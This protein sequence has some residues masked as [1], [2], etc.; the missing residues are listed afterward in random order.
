MRTFAQKPK[1]TPQSTPTR[2]TKPVPAH[3]G[4][5]RAVKSILQLQRTIGNQAVQRLLQPTEEIKDVSLT[6]ASYR[7]THDFSRMPA[8]ASVPSSIQPK[9]KVNAPGDIYEQEADRVADQVMRMP[10]PQLQRAC[11]CGGG[12]PKCKAK[13]SGQEHGLLQTR[14]VQPIG[15]GKAEGPRI[16]NEVLRSPGQP[17]DSATKAFFEP[18]FEH[19]FSHVRVHA[20]MRA[21]ES[22]RA[23]NALAYTVGRHIVLGTNQ[24]APNTSKGKRLIAHELTHVIQQ[25]SSS[26]PMNVEGTL[27][28]RACLPESDYQKLPNYCRDDTFS[29][30]TH[31]GETCYR[32]IPRR[33]SYFSCPPGAHVCFD[34]E[35]NCKESPDRAAAAEA[36][37]AD[38]SCNWNWL[39][40]VKHT[41]VDWLP[42]Q[43]VAREMLCAMR[44]QRVPGYGKFWCLRD[45]LAAGQR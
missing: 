45:C 29:P 22:A 4:Q 17:L 25:Q 18:R 11:A 31:P 2:S 33:T 1:A 16:V 34:A 26:I 8:H 43:P 39:C 21:V 27:I 5:N 14:R 44:C 10:E 36:K 28:Q 37:E 12:C 15:N 24:Y 3:F 13:Q 20:D 38:G 30:T 40:V 42:A 32:E 19:D 6:S 9:L 23:V 7:F 41:L 35:G